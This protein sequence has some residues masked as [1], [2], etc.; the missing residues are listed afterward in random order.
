MLSVTIESG[1]ENWQVFQRKEQKATLNLAGHYQIHTSC[2]HCRLYEARVVVRVMREQDNG[3]VIPWTVAQQCVAED[4]TLRSGRWQAVLTV[5][6]GGLYRVETALDVSSEEPEATRLFGGAMRHHLG[7]GDVF[8]IAGQ[9]NAAGFGMDAVQDPPDVRVHL[10][11]NSK[12]W[13]LATHPMNESTD[14]EDALNGEIGCCGTSPWL[15]FGRSVADFTG[16]PVGLIQTAM[17]GQTLD[18]WDDRICGD[19]LENLGARV[20]LA[21]GQVAA[22]LWYQGCSDA[23]PGRAESYGA[24]FA[25]VIEQL[26]RIVGPVPV[27]TMQ[28]N[29]YLNEDG[30]DRCWGQLR[31]AQ[32]LAA[33]QIPGLYVLP[34]TDLNL[35]DYI[36]NSS[37]ANVCLGLRVA[38]LYAAVLQKTGAGTA[39][40]LCKAIAGKEEICLH[41]SHAGGGLFLLGKEAA[42][43]AFFVQ[44]EKGQVQP[45]SQV[46]VIPEYPGVL[47]LKM[48]QEVAGC[49]KVSFAW[50]CDPPAASVV[51]AVTRMP[52]LSFFEVP[53]QYTKTMDS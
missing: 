49:A 52:P 48:E 7:I 18:R 25:C 29:R 47:C 36:H 10:F 31:E 26:R 27:F 16:C 34:T 28:L 2:R 44:D 20:Q 22:I 32:R 24:R 12:V 39:P 41:F 46:S 17:G 14:A 37:N 8:V 19:L 9:S 43:R 40:D 35:S 53:V 51:D 33:R 13:D 1:A 38:Q 3:V 23:V 42:R 11:R 15:A 50:Q 21:G 4:A 5:P 45:I 6:Q 30:D